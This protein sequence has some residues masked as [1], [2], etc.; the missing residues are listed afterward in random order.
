[1]ISPELQAHLQSVIPSS[2]RAALRTSVLPALLTGVARVA[3]TL[4][5]AQHVSLAGTAN[6]F[7]DDQLNVDVAAEKDIRAALAACGTVVTA[8]SEEDPVEKPVVHQ[9]GITKGESQETYTLAFDPLDGSSIIAPNWSVG[10]IFGVWDGES[11]LHQDPKTR[12][13]VSILGVFGPR[14]TAIV[15]VRTDDAPPACFEVGFGDQGKQ[16]WELMRAHV[17]LS[18][19]P[20]KARYFAP[21]NLRSAGEDARYMALVTHYIS[22]RYNLRY[23][24]GLVPDVAHALTKGHGVYV[25]PVTAGS[26]AKLRKLYELFPVALVVECAGGRAVDPATG[27]DLL[28]RPLEEWDERAGLVCGTAEE[29]DLVKEK[30]LG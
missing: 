27:E 16:T 1:M 12:Q 11:A 9:D 26:R 20:F 2:S 4:R 13:V 5:A 15:A 3:S 18:R 17:Q 19:P 10:A 8:S 25:N 24:G 28:A 23:S 14:T 21:A 30:L 29:V 22:E 7:G 6:A